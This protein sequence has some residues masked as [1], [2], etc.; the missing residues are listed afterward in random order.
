MFQYASFVVLLVRIQTITGFLLDGSVPCY[1]VCVCPRQ[2]SIHCE[3]R[4]LR[5]FPVF[6]LPTD[7]TSSSGL[8]INLDNNK[9]TEIP[10]GTFQNFTNALQNTTLNIVNLRHNHISQIRNGAFLGL[11]NV[12]LQ[13]YLEDNFLTAIPY[14]FTRLRGLQLLFIKNNPLVVTG[15]SDDIVQQIMY[16]NAIMTISLS[17]YELLKKVMKYQ[18]NTIIELHLHDMNETRFDQGLFINGQTTALRKL[19]INSC[20]FGDL[21]EVLCNLDLKV[22]VVDNCRNVHDTTLQ[23]CPQNN[24]DQLWIKSCS[25]T[26]ALDPSAFYSAPLTQFWLSSRNTTHVPKAQLTHWPNL[27]SIFFDTNINQIQKADLEVLTELRKLYTSIGTIRFIDDEVFDK[28]LKLE[29]LSLGSYHPDAHVTASIKHLTRLRQLTLPDIPCS[30]TTMGVLKG[31]NYSTMSIRGRCFNIY[32]KD[33]QAY[34][35]NDI[36]ACP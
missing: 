3:L 21:S 36:M 15:I 18:L 16:N 17:S 23:G 34:L 6:D 22:F 10:F 5:T 4:G 33:I 13:L 20:A 2:D 19:F 31:G 28:N 12:T 11:E 1:D 25:T 32:D 9:L 26:D 14:E 30:C 27:T 24:T 29:I 35:N 8:T 7:F